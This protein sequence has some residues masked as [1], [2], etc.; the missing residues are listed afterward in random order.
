MDENNRNIDATSNPCFVGNGNS[1][2]GKTPN[3]P[4]SVELFPVAIGKCSAAIAFNGDAYVSE[5]KYQNKVN[6]FAN[7]SGNNVRTYSSLSPDTSKH[8]RFISFIPT[9]KMNAASI[10]MYFRQLTGSLNFRFYL[11]KLIGSQ[12]TIIAK[13]ERFSPTLGLAVKPLISPIVIAPDSI[14]YLGYYCDDAGGNIRFLCDCWDFDNS[15]SPILTGADANELD[16]GSVFGIG[17]TPT[18]F[19]PWMIINEAGM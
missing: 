18:Q 19:R 2:P 12:P 6:G 16:I 5:S 11:A 14:Y 8:S 15:T 13:S 9:A 7:I 4:F 10:G 3:S 17:T 1:T